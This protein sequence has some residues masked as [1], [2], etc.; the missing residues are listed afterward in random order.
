MKVR[1]RKP[2]GQHLVREGGGESRKKKR[3]KKVQKME[4]HNAHQ[5]HEAVGEV[6]I[7]TTITIILISK[8]A[9][10]L[11]LVVIMLTSL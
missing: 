7:C 10:L 9:Q 3:I 4:W 8:Q 1:S 2:R 11:C 5:E 6:D